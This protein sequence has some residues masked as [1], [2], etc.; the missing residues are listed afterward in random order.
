M[1]N[2]MRHE[3]MLDLVLG[4][5]CL[6]K[7]QKKNLGDPSALTKE[8]TY[9]PSSGKHIYLQL[10]KL[11]KQWPAFQNVED[12]ITW[13]LTWRNTCESNSIARGKQVGQNKWLPWLL[14]WSELI[15]QMRKEIREER[16]GKKLKVWL[17][18]GGKTLQG[19]MLR[20]QT[21]GVLFCF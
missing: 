4:G 16:K 1:G 19:I 10:K 18:A 3:V 9:N 12:G 14:A 15:S 8:R 20:E 21:V 7:T 5:K 6:L 13:R 17:Y 11:R 2:A